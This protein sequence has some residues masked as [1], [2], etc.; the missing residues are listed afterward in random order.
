MK[1]GIQMKN[2]LSLLCKNE[3]V[4][5]T[6]GIVMGVYVS[7]F[8]KSITMQLRIFLFRNKCDV[9]NGTNN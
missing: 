7:I 8:S 5:D 3:V 6:G 9:R 2:S 1:N 4:W